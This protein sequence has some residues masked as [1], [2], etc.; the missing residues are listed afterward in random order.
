MP[1]LI[2]IYVLREGY[3]WRREGQLPPHESTLICSVPVDEPINLTLG[4]TFTFRLFDYHQGKLEVFEALA[5]AAEL[6]NEIEFAQ[7][8]GGASWGYYA[9]QQAAKL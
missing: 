9:D 5:I 3:T 2:H 6:C 8:A 1:D 4:I 7:S